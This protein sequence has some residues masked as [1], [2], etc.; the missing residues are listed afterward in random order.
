MAPAMPVSIEKWEALR[1][2]M[3]GLGIRE[4]DLV[5]KFVRSGGRG[6]QN[7]NKVATCV[8]LVH[9]PTGTQVKCQ[10]E[11]FQALNRFVARQLLADKIERQLLGAASAEVQRIAKLKRQKR[12]RSR[13]AKEKMLGNKRARAEVKALRAA[14]RE[15]TD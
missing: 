7:V 1:E 4:G 11:R 15:N 6:G 9:R 13:R 8:V 5:E 2:R 12:R 10:R 3:R 14:V